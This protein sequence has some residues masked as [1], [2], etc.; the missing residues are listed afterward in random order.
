MRS[1]ARTALLGNYG[2]MLAAMLL[3]SLICIVLAAASGVFSISRETSAA[4]TVMELLISFIVMII[5]TILQT[6]LYFMALNIA[7]TGHAN[8]RDLFLGFRYHTGRLIGLTL[9]IT[10][11]E[12]LCL[13]PVLF[14]MIQLL[15][16]GS[17]IVLFGKTL[18]SGGMIILWSVI[19]I[20]VAVVL[21]IAFLMLFSQSLFLFIDHQDYSIS[22]CLSGS[23]RM[24]SGNRIRL[25]RLYLSFIGYVLLTALSFGIGNIWT[26]PYL[27]VTRAEFYIALSGNHRPYGE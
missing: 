26:A 14:L 23:A 11:A 16:N 20:L 17:R 2:T 22:Q 7:R 1:R 25:F 15:E 6:G 8:L 3:Y 24:M 21:A 13:A 10:L 12:Y 18:V 19:C 9:V 4:G 27:H 5:I